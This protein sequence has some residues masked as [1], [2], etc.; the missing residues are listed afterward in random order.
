[1]HTI[2]WCCKTMFKYVGF[3]NHHFLI[4]PELNLEIHP[5]H[6]KSGTHHTRGFTKKYIVIEVINCNDEMYNYIL[7]NSNDLT[8]LWYYPFINCE[9]LTRGLLC[10]FPI[11]I[12]FTSI[13]CII[14]CIIFSFFNFWWIIF[15]GLLTVVF[16]CWNNC[17]LS[18]KYTTVCLQT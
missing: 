6:Y 5:G 7:S 4:I 13:I 17:F 10:K 18:R 8:P 15:A 2:L 9:T 14:A 1:M 16:L 12:Q 3:V 11:S